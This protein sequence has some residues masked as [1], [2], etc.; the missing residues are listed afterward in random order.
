M[1]FSDEYEALW[2]WVLIG[3]RG[4]QTRAK[5]IKLLMD[6]PMNKNQ[7]AKTLGLN[8]KTVEHHLRVLQENG[9]VEVI[10]PGKYG[11]L[12]RLSGIALARLEVVKRLVRE[13]L[14]EI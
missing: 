10:N 14:G 7:I 12:Y 5:I 3:S 1:L 11:A 9:L 6:R 13:A 2:W 4:G 8:Y